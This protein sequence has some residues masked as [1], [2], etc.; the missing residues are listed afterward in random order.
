MATLAETV[1][2]MVCTGEQKQ[3][4][5]DRCA[6]GHAARCCCNVPP[7]AG[8]GCCL[9]CHGRGWVYVSEVSEPR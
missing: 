5:P 4:C 2:A 7:Y 8:C 9:R 6:S 1:N 3:P